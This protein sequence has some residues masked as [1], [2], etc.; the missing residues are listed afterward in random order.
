MAFDEFLQGVGHIIGHALVHTSGRS[1]KCVQVFFGQRNLYL[2]YLADD[3]LAGPNQQL[4]RF[5]LVNLAYGD[6]KNRH[7]TVA[8]VFLRRNIDVQFESSI[9]HKRLV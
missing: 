7:Q 4:A 3:C 6:S 2:Q 9:I 8:D 1:V 5:A